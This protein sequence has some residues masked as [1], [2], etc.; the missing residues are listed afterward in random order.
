M[1]VVFIKLTVIIL[2]MER[3]DQIGLVLAIFVIVAIFFATL[4]TAKK[5][6]LT[7]PSTCGSNWLYGSRYQGY[8]YSALEG[9]YCRCSTC[10]LMGCHIEKKR[11]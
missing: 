10:D 11:G 5:C 6:E 7:C 2:S 3:N 4:N 9:C 8:E 1:A